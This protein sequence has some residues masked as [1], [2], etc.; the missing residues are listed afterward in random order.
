MLAHDL[1]RKLLDGPN[2]EVV[3]RGDGSYNYTP[4]GEITTEKVSDGKKATEVVFLESD[5]DDRD[6][7]GPESEEEEG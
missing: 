7:L 1:A 3:V 5:E 6:L 4:T 2:H